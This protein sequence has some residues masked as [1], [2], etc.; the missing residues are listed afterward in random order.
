M[1][2]IC[3]NCAAEY[4]VAA[5]TIP[6]EGRKVRCSACGHVWIQ[7]RTPE[8]GDAAPL[9]RRPVD[10]QA[11]AI[12]REEAAREAE[13]RAAAEAPVAV[14]EP[15]A[16]SPADPL[17]ET[18]DVAPSVAPGTDVPSNTLV[19]EAEPV[20]DS[21]DAPLP[22]A[23]V[24]PLTPEPA[25]DTTDAPIGSLTDPDPAPPALP[26]PQP[27]APDPV[28]AEQLPEP[29]PA[30]PP[31]LPEPSRAPATLPD[32]A[33]RAAKLAAP[34][35]APRRG[36][37][38]TGFVLGLLTVVALSGLYLVA[39]GLSDDAPAAA[40]YLSAYVETV[41]AARLWLHE[42]AGP[43]LARFRP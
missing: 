8:F 43:V 41:D 12:L 4:E 19:A 31:A 5:A 15:V 40:P 27:L 29:K 16:V 14:A 42:T 10:P 20:P 38:G 1:R 33:P 25:P 23:P 24:E 30:P 32:P 3:A 37:F 26:D 36:R 17:P 35:P 22:E 2:L 28:I 18:V 11:L 21:T 34:E 7:P 6:P 13:A 9:P 39:P